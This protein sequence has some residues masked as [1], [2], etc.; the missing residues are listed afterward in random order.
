M[1][2]GI[3]APALSPLTGTTAPV[4]IRPAADIL[5]AAPVMV[6]AHTFASAADR[7]TVTVVDVVR[8]VRAIRCPAGDAIS[9]ADSCAGPSASSWLPVSTGA[10]CGDSGVLITRLLSGGRCPRS[11]GPSGRG[12]ARPARPPRFS[13]Q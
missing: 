8:I 6:A 13:L 9:A 10:G 2:R 3:Q 7:S 1:M 11:A 4:T 5:P 12:P